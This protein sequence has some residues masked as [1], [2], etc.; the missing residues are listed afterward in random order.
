VAVFL[1]TSKVWSQQFCLWLI[2]LAVLARPRWTAFLVW[3]AAEVLYF[4]SFYGEL[5]GASGKQV[6]LEWVFVWASIGR[7]VTLAVLVGLVVRDILYPERDV[8][9]LT[10]GGDPDGGVFDLSR[11][12]FGDPAPDW[13]APRLTSGPRPENGSPP[14]DVA[15]APA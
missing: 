8:V 2:P 9:R 1:L 7:W 3:Q 12:G 13:S 15:P 5:M 14:A 10:Y 6:F 4:V 11:S